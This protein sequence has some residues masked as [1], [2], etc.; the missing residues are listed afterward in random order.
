MSQPTFRILAPL[1]VALLAGAFSSARADLIAHYAFDG[2]TLDPS[3]THPSVAAGTLT[4]GAAFN[5]DDGL[6]AVST[7]ADGGSHS[8]FGRGTSVHTATADS[9]S[10]FTAA[11]SQGN[12]FE[13][14]LSTGSAMDLTSLGFDTSKNAFNLHSIRILVTSDITGHAYLNRL[15]MTAPA[16]VDSS[17][18]DVIESQVAGDISDAPA[19]LGSNWGNGDNA[20]VNLNVPAFQGVSAVTFRVYAFTLGQVGG[21]ANVANVVRFDNVVVNGTVAVPEPASAGLILLALPLLLRRRR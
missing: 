1:A 17:L 5:T 20:L 15:N 3:A 2:A 6:S 9:S 12:Y 4:P 16:T 21:T 8:Y 7:P 18:A 13:F 10:G 19:G 14:T 11:N